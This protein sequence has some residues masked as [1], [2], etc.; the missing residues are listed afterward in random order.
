MQQQHDFFA[1]M[2]NHL[3][4][5]TYD[6]KVRYSGVTNWHQSHPHYRLNYYNEVQ[7]SQVLGIYLLFNK[8]FLS[9]YD[10]VVEI[11]SYNGG[12]SSYIFDNLKKDASFASFDIDPSINES[13]RKDIDFR[14]KD[15]FSKEGQR[16]IIELIQQPGKTLLI[17]DGGDKN[18][19]FNTFS[20][21]LKTDDIIILHDY[22]SDE[23]PFEEVAEFWQWPYGYESEWGAIKDNV[24]ENNLE[25]YEY[26]RFNYFMWG[27]FIKK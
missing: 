25:K 12:L 20:K 22:K 4:V 18:K 21:Y 5:K 23:T 7:I 8:D 24:T 26:Q 6:D 10:T 15:C 3:V 19:E 11:G 16:E 13:N 1:Q 27:S 2:L 9:Q 17:C 14:I